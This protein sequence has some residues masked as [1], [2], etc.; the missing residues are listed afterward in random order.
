LSLKFEEVFF[1]FQ[2]VS[3]FFEEGFMVQVK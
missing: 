1:L 3:S 2:G